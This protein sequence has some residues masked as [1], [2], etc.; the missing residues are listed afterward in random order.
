MKF[1]ILSA[2][3]PPQVSGLGDY[4]VKLA[5]ELKDQN[6]QVVLWT[7]ESHPI[8]RIGV[9]CICVKQPWGW[10][11]FKA[12][13]QHGKAQKPDCLILQYT[14]QSIAPKQFGL[15]PFF[16]LGL[17]F[18]KWKLKCPIFIVFHELNYPVSFSL[19]GIF[20]G[21]CHV[22][23][24]ILLSWIADQNFCTTEY[25]VKKIKKITPR[26]RSVSCLPVG[27]NVE[28]KHLEQTGLKE[29]K[30]FQSRLR[31]PSGQKILLHFGGMHPTHRYDY[32][33]HTLRWVNHIY[34]KDFACLICIGASFDDFEK[35]GFDSEANLL[36]G[37]SV[38]W[39]GFLE[40]HEVSLC[41]QISDLVLAPF[42]DGVSTRRGS[43]M[44]AFAHGKPMM[45]TQ[46][47]SS[48]GSI[49]WEDLCFIV[50]AQDK[51]GFAQRAASILID[52]VAL[53][54]KGQKAKEFYEQKLSWPQ[55]VKKIL[56]K[57]GNSLRR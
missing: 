15:N 24:Y 4:T 43:A 41:F 46:A 47:W 49:Y 30:A 44:A 22:F 29:Q 52:P 12:F 55:V 54:Q 40:E 9:P 3:L 5:L 1:I 36:R 8:S 39:L 48:Q 50:E 23:Q 37:H 31:I 18:L 6:H 51:E 34:G 13:V 56:S 16:V 26:F 45:T 28:P 11:A 2:P 32:I 14:P 35:S 38:H 7:A 53:T 20:I 27:A 42:L 17:L 21:G 19:K 33:F 57:I 10:T 25:F